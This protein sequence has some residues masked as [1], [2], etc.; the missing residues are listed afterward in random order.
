MYLW[1]AKVSATMAF[2]A[3]KKRVNPF[4]VNHYQQLVKPLWYDA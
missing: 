2:G 3:I 4:D 1:F